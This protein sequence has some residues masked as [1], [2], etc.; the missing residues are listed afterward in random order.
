MKKIIIKFF[1]I[2]TLSLVVSPQLYAQDYWGQQSIKSPENFIFG[3]GSLINSKSRNASV[4][5]PISA[6]PVRVSSNFGFVR[7]WNDHSPSE[8][9]ALGLRKKLPGEKSTTING[10]LFPVNGDDMN[11]YDKRE[12]GYVRVSVPLADIE[13]MSWQNLPKHGKV[14]AYV[15]AVEGKAPGED[16]PGPDH[17]FPLLQSYIDLVIEGAMEY[18][19]DYVNELIQT[20]KGW[21][22]HWLND[23][24]LARRPWVA[25]KNHA[26]IDRFL[27]QVPELKNRQLPEDYAASLAVDSMLKKLNKQQ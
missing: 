3:Y 6:I 2:F 12:I 16:V 8:F 23:R 9:T 10:V 1:I 15:P 5:Q 20:S 25:E 4:T 19:D 26:Q 22:N 11:A 14:W 27:K 17:K 13:A 7:A 24:I 21:G 18:G